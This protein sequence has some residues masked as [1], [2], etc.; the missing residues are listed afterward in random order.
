MMAPHW[1]FTR[2]PFGRHGRFSRGL[3][4]FQTQNRL[5]S[6]NRGRIFGM[7]KSVI[8]VGSGDGISIPTALRLLLALEQRRGCSFPLSFGGCSFETADDLWRV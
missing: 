5:L 3:Q 6:A 4:G 7:G 2:N 8:T 1:V